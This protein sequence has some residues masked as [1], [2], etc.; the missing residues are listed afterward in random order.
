M[1]SAASTDRA[2][3]RR[4]DRTPGHSGAPDP[5]AARTQDPSASAP[6]SKADVRRK[7]CKVAPEPKD[8][9]EAE[10]LPGSPSFRIYCQKASAQVDALVADAADDPNLAAR[11]NDPPRCSGE[12]P[13]CKEGWLKVRGQTVFDALYG[14][15]VCHSKRTSAPPAPKPPRRPG[16]ASPAAAAAAAGP[17]L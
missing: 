16:A 3:R 17:Y 14:L 13:K 5:L 4:R 10:A 9:E 2:E 6:A 11:K 12:L 7:G 8:G 1:G 15:F